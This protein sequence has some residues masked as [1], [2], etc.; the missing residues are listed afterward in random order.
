MNN[1]RIAFCGIVT[2][3]RNIRLGSNVTWREEIEDKFWEEA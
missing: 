3:Y 2:V 1:Q